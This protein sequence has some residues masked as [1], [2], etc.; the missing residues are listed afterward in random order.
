MKI[1]IFL[2]NY[3]IL[4][5]MNKYDIFDKSCLN[6]KWISSKFKMKLNICDVLQLNRYKSNIY[7][8][9]INLRAVHNLYYDALMIN[10]VRGLIK[11]RNIFVK[12]RKP[13]YCITLQTSISP[14]TPTFRVS[15]I[16]RMIKQQMGL[17]IVFQCESTVT[18]IA[19][20]L[21]IAKTLIF[22]SAS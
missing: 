2:T 17:Y 20:I 15:F 3:D 12:Y 6:S 14:A 18:Y 7:L 8:R 19:E 21:L 10:M 16:I 9:E 4:I 13:T 11:F 1:I 22:L 5:I